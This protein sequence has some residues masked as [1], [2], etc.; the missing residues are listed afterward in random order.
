MSEDFDDRYLY[1]FIL[2]LDRPERRGLFHFKADPQ[3][4]ADQE[5]R[6]QERN[7]PSPR[8][9]VILGQLRDQSEHA[10]RRQVSDG[11]TDLNHAAE[12][13]ALMRGAVLDDHQHRAAPFTAKADA[14]QEAQHDQQYRRRH[15]D[16]LIGRQQADQKRSQSHY[17]DGEHR[18]APDPAAEMAKNR[19]AQRARQKADRIGPERANRRQRRVANGEEDL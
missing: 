13:T 10:D 6:D 17:D 7:P 1:D 14:L 16:L 18:L 19:R 9:E 5:N 8:H 15:A 4:D 12:E 2:G 11:I 3:S